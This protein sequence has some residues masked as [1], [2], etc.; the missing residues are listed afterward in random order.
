MKKLINLSVLMLMSFALKIQAQ[1]SY[2]LP[3]DPTNKHVIPPSPDTWQFAKYGEYPVS[4]ETGVP[5]ISIPLYTINT[6]ELSLPISLSYHAGGIKVDDIASWVG[7]GWTLNAGGIV[8]RAIRGG[9]PDEGGSGYLNLRAGNYPFVNNQGILDPSAGDVGAAQDYY[10]L[11]LMKDGTLD[12]EPDVF[13]YN[14]SSSSGKFYLDPNPVNWPPPASGPDPAT[15]RK[16]ISQ[17]KSDNLIQA[18]IAYGTNSS[19]VIIDYSGDITQ[20]TITAPDGI[21]YIFSDR[22]STPAVGYSATTSWYLTQMQSPNGTETIN[23]FYRNIQ[24]MTED[25]GTETISAFF[26]GPAYASQPSVTK[27]ATEPPFHYNSVKVLDHIDF[28]AGRVVFNSVDNR[29]DGHKTRLTSIDIFDKN[30]LSTPLKSFDFNNN[31]YFIGTD[32]S[33][34]ANKRLKLNSV[35]E[36]AA[37]NLTLPPHEFTY[38]ENGPYQLPPRA[39]KA[40]DYWGY[41]NGKLN[42]QSLIP[43]VTYPYTYSTP[44]GAY[45]SIILGDADR[46]PNAD[47]MKAGIIS[48]IKFPTGGSTEFSF[49]ANDVAYTHTYTPPPTSQLMQAYA[50]N[51][52]TSP[53]QDLE[54]FTPTQSG[55]GTVQLGLGGGTGGFVHGSIYLKDNGQ[56][57][58]GSAFADQ[59]AN[60]QFPIYVIAGHT[61]ELYA[62]AGVGSTAFVTV[63]WSIPSDPVTITNNQIVGGLRVTDIKNYDANGVLVTRKH[64]DYTNAS[65]GNASS[66]KYTNNK[67][68]DPMDY[69]MTTSYNH[70]NGSFCQGCQSIYDYDISMTSHASN[71]LG[72]PMGNV[73]MYEYVTERDEVGPNTVGKTMYQYDVATTDA[74]FTFITGAFTMDRSWQRGQLLN[75]Y[76]YDKTGTVINKY[77]NYKYELVPVSA[78]IKGLKI[79]LTVIVIDEVI[80]GGPACTCPGDIPESYRFYRAARTLVLSYQEDFSWKRLLSKSETLD[81]VTTTTTFEYDPLMRTTNAVAIQTKDSKNKIQRTEIRYA[82]EMGNTTMMS[83]NMIDIPLESDEKV[84]GALTGGTR[85]T[86]GSLNGLFVPTRFERKLADGTFEILKDIIKVNAVGRVEEYKTNDGVT[87]SLKWGYCNQYPVTKVVNA[88]TI[89]VYYDSFEEAGGTTDSNSKT[90]SKIGTAAYSK[91]LT[92]LSNG[93]YDLTYWK[94]T[95]GIWALVATP[96]TVSS[97]SYTISIAADATTPIDEIR[98]KPTGAQ[99]TTYTYQSLIGMTSATDAN[100]VPQYYDFDPFLRLKW[101]RDMNGNIVK[102]MDYHYNGN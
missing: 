57:V 2:T 14:L 20:I 31:D 65:N 30:N 55:S 9:K 82:T 89:D 34:S 85:L 83:K 102:A 44:T 45:T 98:F 66:G 101:L 84:N 86:Y 95:S 91:S 94:R 97:G 37:G 63:S 76:Y 61:Y 62:Q 79:G 4:R 52:T 59:S 35:Q 69:V 64:Y 25:T 87:N 3:T 81:N 74:D 40:Q 24:D 80:V 22:T 7:L 32:P 28:A 41:Y 92:G 71:R 58:S 56:V 15:T 46:S 73:V 26:A 21:K 60:F 42:N 36:R 16:G 49:Q 13:N 27:R 96:V 23:F 78:P 77:V 12:S 29:E 33:S 38:L 90:G 99:M 43:M 75:E 10:F 1:P 67:L 70:N 51:T 17:P 50:Y 39:S 68:P 88:H 100:N 93:T 18:T 53:Q 54:Q 19:G 6:G 48:K 72:L 5:N 47:N 11:M 8:T